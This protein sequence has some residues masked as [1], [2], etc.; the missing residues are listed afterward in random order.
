M[1][2]KKKVVKKPLVITYTPNE[3]FEFVKDQAWD[4]TAAWHAFC[5]ATGC[6]HDPPDLDPS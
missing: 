4:R 2:A 3:W 5:L 6:D 1:M